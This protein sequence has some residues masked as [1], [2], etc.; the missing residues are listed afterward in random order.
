MENGGKPRYKEKDKGAKEN[1][2]SS[3]HREK[4]HG[5]ME[6]VT[7]ETSGTGKSDA[8]TPGGHR[9]SSQKVRTQELLPLNK[10]ASPYR[11]KEKGQRRKWRRVAEA[12]HSVK[13]KRKA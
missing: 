7:T 13:I 4:A 12:R 11:A 9:R 3:L 10:A 2:A 8:L 5:K 6:P 1:A